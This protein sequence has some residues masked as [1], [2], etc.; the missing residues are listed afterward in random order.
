M[1]KLIYLFLIALLMLLTSCESPMKIQINELENIEGSIINRDLLKDDNSFSAG[2]ENGNIRNDQ[3]T[4]NWSETPAEGFKFYKLIRGNNDVA[5]LTDKNVTNYTDSTLI[6]NMYYDYQ[7]T[8]FTENGMVAS[9]TIEIKT[10]RW[11]A[12]TNITVN[13]LSKTAIK[14]MWDDNSDFENNFKI[15]QFDHT[16]ITLVDSFLVGQNVTEKIITG[17][18]SM[19]TYHFAVEAIS[20][21]EEQEEISQTETFDMDDFVLIPPYNLYGTQL[22]DLSVS[23]NWV[24]YSNMETGFK[25][26]RRINSSEFVTIADLDMINVETYLSEFSNSYSIGSI[27]TFRVLA[28]NDYSGLLE[29]GYSNEFTL[30]IAELPDYVEIGFDSATWDY[31][32]HTGYE[33]AR[34][35]VIYLSD[36]IQ[37]SGYINKIAFN[38][39]NYNYQVMNDFTI[40]LKNTSLSS[41][42]YSGAYDN[43]GFTTCLLGNISIS[44]T[45]WV[46]FV[47]DT[48]YYYNGEENIIVDITINNNYYTSSSYCYSSYVSGL[49]SITN[50]SDSYM[51]NPLYWSYGNVY[52]RI[53]NIKLFFN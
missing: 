23:L 53:P 42:S 9:D 26:E 15:Y 41:F 47:F 6:G 50:Y 28:Y 20:E 29:S 38:I 51:D 32:F 40:R 5:V 33:D 31:P 34:T 49:R 52:D 43:D 10:A 37:N 7:L 8:V 45:G 16:R 22:G 17:L 19:A 3:V 35:Q 11:Q 39:V 30:V 1:Q 25:V 18:D 4:L 46:E 44:E 21:W 27:L 14:L 24:D 2:Y 36:E 48:P 13:G 12:P